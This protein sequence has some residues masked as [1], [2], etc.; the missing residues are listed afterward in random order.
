MHKYLKLFFSFCSYVI[1]VYWRG[2]R[3]LEG[4]WNLQCY[5]KWL[6]KSGYITCLIAFIEYNK[7]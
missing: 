5:N 2:A 7:L 4:S 1:L 6:Q 3:Y